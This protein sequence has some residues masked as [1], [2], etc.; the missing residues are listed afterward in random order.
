MSTR[1]PDGSSFQP[2]S[3]ADFAVLE[4]RGKVTFSPEI[5]ATLNER[6]RRHCGAKGDRLIRGECNAAAKLLAGLERKL[7]GVL[8]ALNDLQGTARA[9]NRLAAW[10]L[11]PTDREQ[12][13][14]SNALLDRPAEA[15]GQPYSLANAI[16]VLKTLRETAARGPQGLNTKTGKPGCPPN[17]WLQYFIVIV[18]GQFKAAGGTVSAAWQPIKERRET[19]F[20]RVLRFIHARLPVQRRAPSDEALDEQAGDSVAF[21]KERPASRGKIGQ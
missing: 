1:L 13:V 14:I 6:L 20:L 11:F 8:T 3:D 18:A 4:D 10:A 7:G 16:Q 9:G 17:L 21:M 2:L 5:R 12:P 19:P 15:P